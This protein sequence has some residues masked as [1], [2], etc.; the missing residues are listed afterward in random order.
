M[1]GAGGLRHS[2]CLPRLLR[3]D[4]FS[5]V[6]VRECTAV[7]TLPRH[8][9]GMAPA[10]DS[11]RSW[12][13]RADRLSQGFCSPA[14]WPMASKQNLR[15]TGF[16]GMVRF[17]PGNAPLDCECHAHARRSCFSSPLKS[18]RL[19]MFGIILAQRFTPTATNML[20]CSRLPGIADERSPAHSLLIAFGELLLSVWLRIALCTASQIKLKR[21]G[22]ALVSLAAA[23]TLAG[24]GAELMMVHQW[25]PLAEL[26]ALFRCSG[27]IAD[28][29]GV[30]SPG[31]R[32]ATSRPHIGDV[33]LRA[34]VQEL[35]AELSEMDACADELEA[36][37]DEL[38]NDGQALHSRVVQ[39]Q[40]RQVL[41]GS[42][43][44]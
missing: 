10:S 38:H 34:R 44:T 1:H 24:L 31:E 19:Q 33:R 26:S 21:G 13:E 6:G 32:P 17:A 18:T 39:L 11:A 30:Q 12:R 43:W 25:P 35:E 36:E 15:A 42:A 14:P 23:N 22:S 7:L 20:P 16:W 27:K 41:S 37:L 29:R 2:M 5:R 28:F 8:A 3:H 4:S 40:V 9:Q